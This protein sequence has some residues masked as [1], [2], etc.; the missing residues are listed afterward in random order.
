MVK[1]V[2]CIEVFKMQEDDFENLDM[3]KDVMLVVNQMCYFQL[4]KNVNEEGSSGGGG[5]SGEKKEGE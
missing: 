4:G 2:N 1:L 5:S 3:L